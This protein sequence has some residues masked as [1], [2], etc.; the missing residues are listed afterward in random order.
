MRD[1]LAVRTSGLTKRYRPEAG[2]FDLDLVVRT[3]EVYGFLGPNGSGKTTTMRMLVG[4]VRPTSGTASV[5]GH[6]AGSSAGLRGVGALIE[7]PALYPHLSGRDNLRVLARYAA[8]PPAASTT[9]SRKWT[10]PREPTSPSARTRS[11]CGSGSR[12]RPR[13]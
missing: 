5:L 9:C 12:W 13:S 7:S 2:V 4:L 11:A 3:G 1:G 8:L 6:P 10:W